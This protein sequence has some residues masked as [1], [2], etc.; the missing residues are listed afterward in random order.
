M[1]NIEGYKLTNKGNALQ[2]KV[3]AGKCKLDITK[4]KLGSGTASGDIVNLTDLVKVEQTVPIS[5][6]EVIDDYTCRITGLVTN[7][8][9]NK[10]YYIREIGLYA[11]DPDDGEILYLV[12][13]DKNPDV[14]PADNYQMVI[15]QEFNIDVVVSNVDSVNVT[16]QPVHLVTSDEVNEKIEEHNT[17]ANPHENIFKR[18]LIT[19]AKTAANT[20]DWNTLTESRTYKI[21]GATFAADKH[22]P[23]GAIGT[24]ELVVL[25]NG[26]DTI[27]QVYYANSTEFDKAGAYHRVNIGGTWTDWVYNITNKGGTIENNLQI[28]GKLVVPN[29][30]VTEKLLIGDYDPS[31]PEQPDTSNFL[32]KDDLQKLQDRII[33]PSQTFYIS[34]TGSNETG[35]GT[36]TKPYLTLDF[37][38][39]K[40][41]KQ[42]PRITFY[43]DSRTREETY[44]MH[45]I[46]L[47]RQT[48]IERVEIRAWQN[49]SGTKYKANLILE[50]GKVQ[51][52]D[53]NTV[54]S[55]P[56][57]Y[58][59]GNM[60]L[61]TTTFGQNNNITLY[62]GELN[63][64][65]GT[66]NEVAN[67][68]KF[69]ALCDNVLGENVSFNVDDYSI[70]R[71]A[72]GYGKT[73]N[74]L[75]DK[76]KT[77][78]LNYLVINTL[79]SSST[80]IVDGGSNIK[81]GTEGFVITDLEGR[82]VSDEL[83]S[84]NNGISPE[85]SESRIIYKNITKNYN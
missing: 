67:E 58:Y 65:L 32:T 10:T 57:R 82:Y 42:V 66:R 31:K 49:I 46:D 20:T 27:V 59:W 38:V 85:I 24:G 83:I 37:A 8:G 79:K 41:N 63:I 6:I 14:M 29:V 74:I 52:S 76:T 13:V 60:L 3:E 36:S 22:Q 44:H 17:S 39:K 25:K 21:S 71:P 11:Q 4:L 7:Q 30:Y 2:I 69:I 73:C 75:F 80:D 62:L 23:V 45:P 64:S 43:L 34:S 28:N 78:K 12:A 70:W 77:N 68:A 40:M 19:E 84:N 1:P 48:Q 18:V 50:Y 51:C 47:F 56:T 61:N 72:A 35:D 54:N 16:S 53:N 5:K 81:S 55:D 15:S 9:L 33:S 26:D